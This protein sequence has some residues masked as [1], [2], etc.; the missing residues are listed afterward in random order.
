[1]SAAALTG[2]KPSV[3]QIILSE[4]AELMKDIAG[5]LAI[6]AFI[7]AVLIWAY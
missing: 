2:N 3:Q 5:F 1:M 6:A 7:T 4:H